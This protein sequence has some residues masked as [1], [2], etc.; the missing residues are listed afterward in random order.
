MK[1]SME[2]LLRPQSI[3]VLCG[4]AGCAAVARVMLLRA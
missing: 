3:A 1:D 2:A 4:P